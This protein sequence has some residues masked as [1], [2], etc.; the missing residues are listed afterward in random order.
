MKKTKQA[1]ASLKRKANPPDEVKPQS[2]GPPGIL[3]DGPDGKLTIRPF[4]DDLLNE[5]EQEPDHT[6]LAEYWRVIG[7]LREKGLTFREIAEWLSERNIDA[8]R[9][10]VY[11]VYMKYVSDEE[12]AVVESDLEKREIELRTES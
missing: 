8:D 2:N 3:T 5:A 4:P 7:K 12:I 11:R 10:A 6:D 9:N 1:K